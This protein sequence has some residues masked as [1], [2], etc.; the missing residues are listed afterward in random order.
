MTGP[1]EKILD[2]RPTGVKDETVVHMEAVHERSGSGD[3]P[4]VLAGIWVVSGLILVG[5]GIALNS[6]P[7]SLLAWMR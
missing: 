5:V 3:S 1:G 7:G 6:H 2:S 4:V